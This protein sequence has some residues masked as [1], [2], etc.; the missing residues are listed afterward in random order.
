MQAV[1]KRLIISALCIAIVGAGFTG[2]GKINGVNVKGKINIV[3]TIFPQ[4]DWVM[5]L[6]GDR[7]DE[8]NVTLLVGNGVD[9]HSYQPTARDIVTISTCDFFIYVGGESDSWVEDVLERADN[10]DINVINMMEV[11]GDKTYV[12]EIVE[13]MEE[14]DEHSHEGLLNWFNHSE[15]EEEEYD[16]HVWLSLKNATILCSNISDVL[17]RLDKGHEDNYR[18]SLKNYTDKLLELN[19]RYEEVVKQAPTKT[20]LFGDR[21]PFRYMAEDYGLKYYAAFPGCSAETEA[22]FETVV[23]LSEKLSELSLK[24]VCITESADESLA[25]TIIKNSEAKSAQTVVFNSMQSVGFLDIDKGVTYLGVME[26]NLNAL[27]TVL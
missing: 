22:S 17:C 5:N 2:C 9:L 23:F 13:G 14:E 11:L 16:E 18:N 24:A 27:K 8:Y 4:Y 3:C 7:A 12:E 21:F 25:H 20:I 6:L 26:D 1:I 15:P 19:G 10:P